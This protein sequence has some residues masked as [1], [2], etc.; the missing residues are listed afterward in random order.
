MKKLLI[1]FF[2]LL[3]AFLASVLIFSSVFNRRETVN[4][5]RKSVV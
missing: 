5:D 3:F 2:V 4:T 1:K